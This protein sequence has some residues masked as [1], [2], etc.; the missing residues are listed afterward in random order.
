MLFNIEDVKNLEW[1]NA[2]HTSFNCLV[3]YSQFGE[4]LPVG[5]DPRDEYE[6]IQTLWQNG[7]DGVYGQITE[8][9][10][11]PIPPLPEPDPNAGEPNVI[12]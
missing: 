6:H 4:Y 11:P 1:N 3:K 7:I 9:V 10:P 8:Y 12:A 5:A 2:E